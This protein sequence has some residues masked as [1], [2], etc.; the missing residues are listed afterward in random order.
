MKQTRSPS[1]QGVRVEHGRLDLA[2]VR[3]RDAHGVF[4]E[5]RKRENYTS[6]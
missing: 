2:W 6:A 3:T 1:S 4:V 5:L